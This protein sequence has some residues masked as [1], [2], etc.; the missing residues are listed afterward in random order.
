[1]K[2][3]IVLLMVI[4]FCFTSCDV[5]YPIIGDM[6]NQGTPDGGNTDTG[7]SNPDNADCAHYVTTA[8]N[9]VKASCT[10]EG[11]S[12]DI[13]CFNCGEVVK[14]GNVTA[15]LDHSFLD[16]VC[17]VCG[18]NKPT[19]D[20]PGDNNPGDNNPGDNNP[21]DNNPGDNNP[22]DNNPG[23][24]NPGDN[25]PDG[26]NTPDDNGCTTHTDTDNNGYCDS[27]NEYVVVIVDIYAINDLHGKVLPS[28]TQPG[29]ASLTT[30]LKTVKT[31]NAIL[32]SSGDMWQG[33]SESNLTHG[34]IVTEW[35]NAM[36][37]V[38]MTLGNHEYD[39]G[40]DYIRANAELADF[41]LL[42]INVYSSATNQRADYATPSVIV[43]RGDVQIGV[44]GAVGDCYSSI[45]GAV[46]DGFYFKT[47]NELANLVKAEADMLRA[48]GVD[49]IIYSI[50]D[51]DTAYQSVLSDG[52]V[53]IV[54]EAHT[55]QTY[56]SSDSDGIYHLQ[57]GGENKGITYA[58]VSINYAN[59]KT[60]VTEAKTIKSTVYGSYAE[61]PL[62]DELLEKY[63]EEISGAYE[64][65][66]YN[67]KKRDDT[68]FEQMVAQLYYEYGVAKWG[69]KY[70]IVLGGG[71]IRTR[72]PYDLAKGDVTYSDVYSLLPFDNA[73]T[74]CSI[75]GSDLKKKFIN[76]TNSD[77]YIYGN[78][79]S[80]TINDNSTYYIVTDTYT[81]TYSSNKLTEIEVATDG[82][83]ARDLV[84][85]FIRKGGWS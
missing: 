13:V 71:F 39:W 9:Y 85:D 50:H 62:I 20:T 60:N 12:G 54:F 61:D 32:L 35:M 51:D 22:G 3:L 55:H 81:S 44:I 53:D 18:T 67:A 28:D 48:M 78:Y 10:E 16:G 72:N 64:D 17:T 24:N 75:K 1:M 68:E 47:G 77:Y 41:P 56:V 7:G 19:E 26:G 27:C 2:K 40:E 74:L 66:G 80:M 58:L 70:N 36:N 45:S 11:Y 25:N 82:V 69:D 8:K 57:G 43:T 79:K 31:Q 52:Y 6:T 73:L 65:L 38:S 33:S 23:D 59:G 46:S 4:A 14:A 42:A 76:T 63:A 34:A 83:Y 30:Y 49:F 29:I 5:L 15:K 84:A 37:F 21:G